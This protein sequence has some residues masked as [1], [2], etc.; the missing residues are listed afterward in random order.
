MTSSYPINPSIRGD[1][2]IP[3]PYFT[4]LL[5]AD[6]NEPERLVQWQVHPAPNNLFRYTLVDLD[7]TSEGDDLPNTPTDPRVLAIYDHVGIV[8][9]LPTD[10]SEGVLLLREGGNHVQEAAIIA[11][12]LAIL[13]QIREIKQMQPQRQR[14]NSGSSKLLKKVVSL[15]R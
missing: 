2:T 3:H 11:S 12:L 13:W 9:W 8:V 7:A 10:H 15:V 1:Y 6:L 5:P 14:K 4:F